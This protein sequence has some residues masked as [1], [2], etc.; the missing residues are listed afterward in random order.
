MILSGGIIGAPM[1]GLEKLVCK[2]LQ[3]AGEV[4]CKVTGIEP[5]GLLCR[6]IGGGNGME[7]LY[8]SLLSGIPAVDS[9]IRG[10]AFP[11]LQMTTASI[12]LGL[13]ALVPAVVCDEKN[14]EVV[15]RS[16]KN[17]KNVESL[18][19]AACTVMGSKAGFTSAPLSG[20]NLKKIAIPNCYSQAWRLGRIMLKARE[21]K[22][23]PVAAIASAENG[24]IVFKGKIVDVIRKTAAGF[25]RGDVF[26]S[27]II[28]DTDSTTT[29]TLPH[30]CKLHFQNEYLSVEIDNEMIA[31]VP[32]LISI[33]DSETARAIGTEELKFG[34][35]VSVIT[36]PCNPLL[37]TEK[38]LAVVGPRAFGMDIDFFS[39]CNSLGIGSVYKQPQSAILTDK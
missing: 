2:K 29:R 11:E 3:H 28:S 13:D 27:D 4:L 30:S 21:E 35:R 37:T 25:T 39:G 32:N 22:S 9:C 10:R 7:L 38:A 31:L 19:R 34:L 23:D 36:I 26:I 5:D 14:N 12:Y 15:I 33:L 6:E 17:P 20:S 8:W 18:G 1:V 24:T 16:A